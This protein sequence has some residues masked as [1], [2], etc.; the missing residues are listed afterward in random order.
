MQRRRPPHATELQRRIM[1][2]HEHRASLRQ[3]EATRYAGR[4]LAAGRI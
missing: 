1:G 4:A 3:D 2:A